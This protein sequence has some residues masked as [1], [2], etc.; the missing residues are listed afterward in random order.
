MKNLRIDM[1]YDDQSME[2]SAKNT[3]NEILEAYNA[4]L[5]KMKDAK[6][7]SP[8]EVKRYQEDTETVK[9]ASAV[10]GDKII[11]NIMELKTSL[12]NE[13][14]NLEQKMGGEY[15]QLKELQEAIKIESKNLHDLYEIKQSADSLAT[16]LLAQ[17]ECK[18]KFEQ[19]MEQRSQEL[20]Q[21]IQDKARTFEQ[22]MANKKLLWNRQEEEYAYN[23]KIERKKDKDVYE[24][25]KAGL[26]K[27]LDESRIAFQKEIEEREVYLKSKE[28]E[29]LDLQTKVQDFPA[30]L[31]KAVK[32]TE[33]STR[34][35][36][37][38]SYKH[39]AALFDKEIEGERKLKD[40][41][42]ASLRDKIKEQDAYI[43]QLTLKA[44]DSTKQVQSIALKAI[45]G[46]SNLRFY[47]SH[48]EEPKKQSQ[49]NQ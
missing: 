19:E 44:N 37:E 34:D 24:A 33:K 35:S 9:K 25:K 26:E 49:S 20:E 48:Q 40:Q 32:D 2:V 28:E 27:E 22:D 39:K 36:I 7:A 13:L 17:K 8:Q 18:Q 5:A 10:S 30:Q 3:K 23:L 14:D 43:D 1:S 29:L 4:L 38:T 15:R 42:I 45:E 12:S 11:K 46:A 6:P 41:M 21:N 31:D 47:A 16:L